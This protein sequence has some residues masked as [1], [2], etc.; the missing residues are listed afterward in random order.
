MFGSAVWASAPDFLSAKQL[1]REFRCDTAIAA[2]NL[3][4]SAS[5]RL[6]AAGLRPKVS[7]Y[8]QHQLQTA[9]VGIRCITC[10]WPKQPCDR[11]MR[12]ASS[13]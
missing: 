10:T 8:L 12:S 4:D 9:A 5:I 7:Q 2:T 3:S 11:T 1:L 6:D 13:I